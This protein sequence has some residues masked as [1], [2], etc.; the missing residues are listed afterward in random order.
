M[1]WHGDIVVSAEGLRSVR[2]SNG[3]SI[4]LLEGSQIEAVQGPD[5][6]RVLQRLPGVTLTRNGGLGSFSGLSV[7]GAASDSVLVLLDGARL[8]D[9]AGPAGGFDF[10][11]LMSASVGRIEL[12]RG[13]SSVVWGSDAIGGV[14]HLTSPRSDGL[15]ASAEYGGDR[16]FSGM[17][18][19]GTTQRDLDA[20]VSASF[21]TREGF[22]SAASGVEAD[23]FEQLA[24]HSRA[25]FALDNSLAVFGYARYASGQSE[26]DGFPAPDFTLSDTAER[27]DTRQLS[28][29][30]G[31]EYN[32]AKTDIT[33]SLAHA[34]T[35]RD[36]V[37]EAANPTPYYST[38]GR[39]NRV[40]LRAR[41]TVMDQLYIVAGGDW[42]R[43]EFFDGT[44]GASARIGSV[45]ALLDYAPNGY[46][47]YNGISFSA[48]AR[49]D[50]HDQFGSAWSIGSDAT[51]RPTNNVRLT[52]SV[53]DGFKAP[54]L[55]QLYSDYGNLA[56]SPERSRSYDVGLRYSDFPLNVSLAIFRRDSRDLIDF[57]GCF[58][59]IDPICAD[60]PYGTYDNVGSARSQGIET[61][62]WWDIADHLSFGLAYAFITSTNRDTGMRL[63]R[64]PRHAGTLMLDWQALEALMLGA[65]LRVVSASFDDAA[66]TVRLGGHATLD[67]R[68]SWE[69]SDRFELYGRI[70]NAWD[71]RYQTAAGY[72]TQGRAAFVGVRARL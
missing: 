58:G 10:G 15:E 18:L 25:K 63:A 62:A 71:E 39:S 32:A 28:A 12:Q 4:S 60:R 61:E 1:L 59:S 41:Q 5:I 14:V 64:R 43:T 51:W 30:A 49:Y 16:Q 17:V 29:R 40:E 37:D 2:D 22:S 21:V 9:V 46:G 24:L 33:A 11:S 36:L 35:E 66:N 13:S 55:F 31:I 27:Q 47:A 26:I 65:D 8:N 38:Q 68:A 7:R 23:G 6:A 20:A 19:L 50:N 3:I 56:L 48:G 53:G 34:G 52:A 42:E 44:S 72:A 70:E 67:L 69:V 57:V 54:S 45:H